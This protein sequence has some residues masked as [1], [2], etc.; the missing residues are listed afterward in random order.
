M[1]NIG[2]NVLSRYL[3]SIL[4]KVSA[5]ETFLMAENCLVEQLKNPAAQFGPDHRPRS[6]SSVCLPDLARPAA[7]FEAVVVFPTPP[8]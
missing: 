7:T 6:T 2:E 5:R 3:F 8:F 1:P 4:K